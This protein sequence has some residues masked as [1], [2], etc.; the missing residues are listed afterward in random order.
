MRPRS[1]LRRTIRPLRAP[2]VAA[3]AAV[4]VALAGPQAAN[5]A[6]PLP[7]PWSPVNLVAG[8]ANPD[9]APGANDF[10][11]KPAPGTRPV[12]LVHGLGA[13]LGT[14]WATFA[15]LLKNNG[16]CVFGL[17]YGRSAGFPYVA[18]LQRM[19]D[20]S[21]ELQALVD[22][23]LQATGADKVDL[24][25]HSEGTVMP[26]WYLSFRG[27]AAK[28]DKYVQ[29]TP[30]WDGT[31][32]AGIGDLVAADKALG[33]GAQQGLT[34]L[35]SPVCGSCVQFARGSDYLNAVN[36]AGPAIPSIH[37]TEIATKYDELV[38]PYT[39][40]LLDAPNVKNTVLQDVCPQDMSEHLAVAYSP[41]VAQ[42][43]LNA[44]APD[45]ARPVRCV[46]MLPTGP[47]GTVPDIGLEPR[48]ASAAKPAAAAQCASRRFA[49]RVRPTGRAIRSVTVRV[50]G[51]KVA[52]RRAA[53]TTAAQGRWTATVDL[54]RYGRRT[55]SVVSRAVLRAKDAK[56]RARV[57][58][59]ARRYRTCGA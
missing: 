48:S 20:S 17:T 42:L 33:L 3:A 29:L 49:I 8:G 50:G 31:N 56:G 54:T 58:T 45:R 59:D 10:S 55:V 43:V 11:C 40:G 22:K 30:L 47:V 6:D 2:L 12:V 44:L 24:L 4:A 9:A 34:T 28:V 27:G 14:N 15:P 51:R 18:G 5:A 13:T 53:G 52:T 57:V 46:T 41:N 7:V 35:L 38:Q 32:L 21:A 19:E 25:G 23:V 39:S 26:R 36:A 16:F 37:Y 1:A